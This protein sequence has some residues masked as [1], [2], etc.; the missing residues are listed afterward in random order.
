MTKASIIPICLIAGILALLVFFATS[1]AAPE[2]GFALITNGM[3]EAQVRTLLGAPH[4]IGR[5]PDHTIFGY[6]GFR[7][8]KWCT[9]TVRFDTSGKVVSKFHDH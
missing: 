7:R 3:T 2:P 8:L 4:G 9:M 6:G 1:E 5:E